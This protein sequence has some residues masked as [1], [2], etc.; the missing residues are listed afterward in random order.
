MRLGLMLLLLSELDALWVC[1]YP[2]KAKIDI[3][4]C[5]TK[6]VISVPVSKSVLCSLSAKNNLSFLHIFFYLSRAALYARIAFFLSGYFGYTVQYFSEEQHI[7]SL[8]C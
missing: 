3:K 4:N 5:H 8:C 1:L 2:A 7:Q 6:K